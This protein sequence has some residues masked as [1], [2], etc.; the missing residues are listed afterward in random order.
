MR[1]KVINEVLGVPSNL[2]QTSSRAFSKILNWIKGINPDVLKK[3]KGAATILEVNFNISDFHVSSLEIKLKL[4]ETSKTI[5]P[6]LVSM[7]VQTDVRKTD[8]TKF[9]NLKTDNIRLIIF[10]VI[11]KGFDYVE[12]PKFLE[13]NKNEVISNLSHEFKHAYDHFKQEYENPEKR[14][15]YAAATDFKFNFQP[16]DSFLH[17][18]Y[19]TTTSENLV[20]PSEITAAIKKGKIS[21]KSFLLF[22]QNNVIYRNLKRIS[23][24]SSEEFKKD[25]LSDKKGLNKL[26]KRLN[27]DPKTMSDE[28]KY[29]ESIKI[30]YSSIMNKKIEQF[31][32]LMMDNF[33]ESILGFRGEK[34]KIFQKFVKRNSVFE[35]NPQG[36]I[37]AYAKY[38]RFISNQM[39]RKIS[40]LYALTRK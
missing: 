33:I 21:Q 38:F 6:Q 28:E 7:G 10:I 40:K 31:K 8:Y 4:F 24:F 14:A 2:I 16:F 1:K 35:N 3:N 12:L 25:I 15:I 34:E 11:P 9:E 20:R 32:M 27:L 36:F 23:N 30:L 18:I 13:D 37:D 29:Q 26:L 39:L 19:F 22:L 17:D 5:E